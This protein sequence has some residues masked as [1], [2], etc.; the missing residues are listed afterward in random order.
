MAVISK[1]KLKTKYNL[2]MYLF[3]AVLQNSAGIIKAPN[4]QNSFYRFVVIILVS[5]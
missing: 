3:R 4:V 2:D 5:I 1:V